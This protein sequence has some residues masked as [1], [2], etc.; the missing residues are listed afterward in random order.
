MDALEEIQELYA[1]TL[2]EIDRLEDEGE[3]TE[4]EAEESRLESE[5]QYIEML[6]ALLEDTP[7][8]DDVDED[9]YDEA[10][11]EY[12]S[13]ALATFSIANDLGGSIATLID[14]NYGDVED[15]IEDLCET[16][17]HAPETIIGIIEGDLAPDYD[18]AAAIADHF[19]LEGDA[20]DGFAYL[21]DDAI[22]ETDDDDDD[23]YDEAEEIA[24]AIEER[25]AEYSMAFAQLQA[26]NQ[27]LQAEFEAAQ[28]EQELNN[29]L[30]EQEMRAQQGV[31]EGWLPPSIYRAEFQSF[32]IADDRIATFSTVCEANKVDAATELYAREKMLEAFERFGPTINFGR[33]IEDEIE[34]EEAQYDQFDVAQARGVAAALA[35]QFGL[36][37]QSQ[38]D[39]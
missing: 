26:E 25:D 11:Y 36:R 27:A 10:D 30:I 4:E 5:E 19:G 29:E 37:S 9:E 2:N 23:D 16:T 31:A 22:S 8:M 33:S 21:V 15:A 3:L 14:E 13:S 34:D 20:R 7:D 12:D 1:D 6:E 39:Y 32:E 18:L 38:E 35:N 17:G 28:A 24:E